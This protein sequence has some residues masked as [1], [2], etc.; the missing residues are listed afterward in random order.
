MQRYVSQ[1]DMMTN[2]K[3]GHK[4]D[5]STSYR[6]NDMSGSALTDHQFYLKPYTCTK[7]LE[8]IKC[9]IDFSL[10]LPYINHFSF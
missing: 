5:Y 6:R 8:D 4:L 7:H 2:K 10:Q 3:T 9:V 1:S